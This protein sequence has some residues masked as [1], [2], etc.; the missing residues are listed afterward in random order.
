M[1]VVMYAN[2]PIVTKRYA[3]EEIVT[4]IKQATIMIVCGCV[5]NV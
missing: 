3:R 5:I 2:V 4:I 1:D